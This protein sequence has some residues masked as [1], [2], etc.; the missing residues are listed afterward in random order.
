MRELIKAYNE[1]FCQDVDGTEKDFSRGQKGQAFYIFGDTNVK[2]RIM[3]YLLAPFKAAGQIWQ[4]IQRGS[5][6][7]Y[8]FDVF[9]PQ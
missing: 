9:N 7:K 1:F 5:A 4:I 8:A 3:N 2:T 6:S